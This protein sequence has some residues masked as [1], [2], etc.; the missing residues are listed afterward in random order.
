VIRRPRTSAL[1]TTPP[2]DPVRRRR[3]WRQARALLAGGIAFGIGAS[4]TVAAWNDTESGTGEFRA[5]EFQLE[6]NIDGTW[7]ATRQMT[8]TSGAMF[9][10]AVTYA[11]VRLRTTPNTTVPGDMTVTGTGRTSGSGAIADHLEY[12]AVIQPVT[13]ATHPTCG[14]GV[15]TTSATYAFGSSSSWQAMSAGVVSPV[16]RR[17][18]AAQGSTLQ[19]CF[20]VRLRSNAPNSAQ[21]TRAGYTWTWDATSVTPG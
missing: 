9:P 3:R 12:R 19:Y 21:G 17:L 7:N 14:A 15:F 4:V 8:F 20:E 1:S 2:R 16:A 13:G 11:P 5:G 6:A 18:D 10:G